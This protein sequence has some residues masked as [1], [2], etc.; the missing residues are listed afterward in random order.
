MLASAVERA[1]SQSIEGIIDSVAS[2]SIAEALDARALQPEHLAFDEMALA[3]AAYRSFAEIDLDLREEAI[4]DLAI[5]A[6]GLLRIARAGD[7]TAVPLAR[8]EELAGDR[9][10][11]GLARLPVFRTAQRVA[12]FHGAIRIGL[13]TLAV[14]RLASEIEIKAAIAR[15]IAAAMEGELNERTQGLLDA[16]RG[17]LQIFGLRRTARYVRDLIRDLTLHGMTALEERGVPRWEAYA[18]S[19]EIVAIAC[20]SVYCAAK[21]SEGGPAGDN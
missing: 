2:D 17:Y 11:S 18:M 16:I 5:T 7:M 4:T 12:P 10:L 14:A 13:D 3:T 8:V 19:G 20:A 15:G 6:P 1:T 21:G 9:D